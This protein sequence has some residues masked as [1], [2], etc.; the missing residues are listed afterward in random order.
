MLAICGPINR[1]VFSL[2]RIP[3][4]LLAHKIIPPSLQCL[5]YE[6]KTSRFE[7]WLSLAVEHAYSISLLYF[8][9]LLWLQLAVS[10]CYSCYNYAKS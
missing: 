3:L 7:V 8:N 1:F 5:G 4:Q 2:S 10:Q 6:V 9:S